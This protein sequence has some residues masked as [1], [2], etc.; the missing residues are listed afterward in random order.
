MADGLTI[1]NFE[2][3]DAARVTALQAWCVQACPD[4]S[5]FEPGFWLSPGFDGGKNIFC[6]VNGDGTLIG[7]VSILP[8]H[9]SEPLGGAR[10]LAMDLRVAPTLQNGGHLRDALL[11]RAVQ[12]AGGLKKKLRA[13]EAVL[14][15]TYFSDGRPSI[16]Y[17]LARGFVRYDVCYQMQRDLSRPIPSAPVPEGVDVR[18]CRMGTK[19]EQLRYVRAFE[20]VFD[21]GTWDL[22]SLQHFMQS[23]MWSDGV[24]MTAF[25]E[26]AVAGSVMAYY[27]PDL[28][29]NPDR[30]GHTENVF[31]VPEWRRRGVARCLLRESLIYLKDRGMAAAQLEPGSGND[32]ALAAYEEMGYRVVQEELSLGLVLP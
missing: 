20:S 11:E 17:L 30:I 27:D 8:A 23:D 13:K 29:R 10:V 16:E 26:T 3:G 25:D 12:C 14:S 9:T 24:A 2:P 6:A 19:R 28:G 22:E 7:Y 4:T 32:P 15:A 18:P 21:D 1:R 5:V 31:V